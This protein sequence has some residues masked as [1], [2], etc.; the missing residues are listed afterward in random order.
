MSD[1]YISAVCRRDSGVETGNDVKLDQGLLPSSR[2]AFGS[3]NA[4]NDSSNDTKP[5]TSKRGI[6]DTDIEWSDHQEIAVKKGK[7]SIETTTKPRVL[8]PFFK[9]D[10]ERHM[11]KVSCFNRGFEEMSRLK[12]HL[13]QEHSIPRTTLNYFKSNGFQ[14]LG[15]I[16]AKWRRVYTTLFPAVTE[17]LI[18]SPY[19]D[20]RTKQNTTATI[21]DV[22]EHILERNNSDPSFAAAL[23]NMLLEATKT[24]STYNSPAKNFGSHTPPTSAE[25]SPELC[26]AQ[27]YPISEEQFI[28]VSNNDYIDPLLFPDIALDS[29]SPF[30]TD[31]ISYTWTKSEGSFATEPAAQSP[32]SD[33]GPSN[34]MCGNCG[35]QDIFRTRGSGPHFDVCNICHST[36]IFYRTVIAPVQ[37]E[38]RS[39]QASGASMEL[40]DDHRGMRED[41][42]WTDY[43][44]GSLAGEVGD[45]CGDIDKLFDF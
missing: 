34:A 15:T 26:N 4:S 23:G 2:R 37:G 42:S 31:H 25:S 17:D 33:T 36:D 19:K 38:P 13:V 45:M 12:Q 18:P 10:P 22:F 44:A 5:K 28:P 30:E 40:P 35:S 7:P 24:E 41:I 21:I 9:R 27:M 14:Q 6:C 29:S 16:E 43:Y 11:D 1:N 20:N 39:R 3:N 8:C 32:E